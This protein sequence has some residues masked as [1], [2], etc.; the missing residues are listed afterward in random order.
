MTRDK[1]VRLYLQAST[2]STIATKL[3]TPQDIRAAYTDRGVDWHADRKT[4]QE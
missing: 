2:A 3:P 1:F 4:E